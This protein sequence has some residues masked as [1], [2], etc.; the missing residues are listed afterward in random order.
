MLAGLGLGVCVPGLNRDLN[1]LSIGT[2]SL[3]VAPGLRLMMYPILAK[4]RYEEFGRLRGQRRLFAI[5]LALNWLVAPM[6][7][8]ALAW[9]LIPDHAAYLTGI[10]IVGIAPRIAMML[11]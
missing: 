9:L 5:T 10:V 8:F 7:M 2:I 3:P 1:R 11:V 6:V 4:V